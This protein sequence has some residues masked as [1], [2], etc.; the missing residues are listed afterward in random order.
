MQENEGYCTPGPHGKVHSSRVAA[1]IVNYNMPER[2]DSIAEGIKEH[3]DWPVRYYT[4]A[5]LGVFWL[6]G[7]ALLQCITFHTMLMSG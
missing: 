7:R 2:T 4:S 1:I 6:F 3:V 5:N